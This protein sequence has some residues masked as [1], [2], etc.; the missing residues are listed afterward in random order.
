[1]KTTQRG[2]DITQFRRTYRNRNEG[3]LRILNAEDDSLIEEI[4][5]IMNHPI[6]GPVVVTYDGNPVCAITTVD[7]SI[8]SYAEIVVNSSTGFVP[9][10]VIEY[11]FDNV[12][13]WVEKSI[14]I[15]FR[16]N[17]TVNYQIT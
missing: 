2:T 7:R 9:A 3:G 16:I 6:G 17:T 15:P 1:M 5:L 11:R 12:G 10:P 4:D 13:I 14:T 8:N